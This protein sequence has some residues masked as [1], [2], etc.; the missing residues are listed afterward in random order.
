[1]KLSDYCSLD[2]NGTERI[3]IDP[4]WIISCTLHGINRDYAQHLMRRIAKKYRLKEDVELMAAEVTVPDVNKQ[5]QIIGAINS[6]MD[7]WI[8]AATRGKLYSDLHQQ[9][10]DPYYK[11]A[12]QYSFQLYIE[13]NEYRHMLMDKLMGI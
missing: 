9:T 8:N 11:E 7:L 5:R 6:A 12:Q 13:L 10:G 3:V 4:G 2:R 1:M